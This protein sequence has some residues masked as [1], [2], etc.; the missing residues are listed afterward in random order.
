MKSNPGTDRG[1][2]NDESPTQSVQNPNSDNM[3]KHLSQHHMAIS[4][5]I[6][7]AHVQDLKAITNEHET[8]STNSIT[9][10]PQKSNS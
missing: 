8:M 3:S 5:E 7:K 1:R 2:T 4:E 9:N 6:A 10:L